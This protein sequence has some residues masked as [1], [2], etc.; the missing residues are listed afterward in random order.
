MY[1]PFWLCERVQLNHRSGNYVWAEIVKV[2]GDDKVGPCS[3][4]ARAYRA[5]FVV[6]TKHRVPGRKK[7]KRK[8]AVTKTDNLRR[9]L[10]VVASLSYR[11]LT[12]QA[13]VA[14]RVDQGVRVP[15]RR[16]AAS[17]AWQSRGLV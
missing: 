11:D 9:P 8:H 7:P 13:Q 2:L 15:W 10:Y 6:E 1:A 4:R 3:T 17:G 14:R 16:H 12:R 5:Q